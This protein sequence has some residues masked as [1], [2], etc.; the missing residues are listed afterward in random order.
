MSCSDSKNRS[1]GV[2]M[3]IDTSGTYTKQLFRAQR[4]IN[5]LLVN[6]NVGDSLAVARIDSGS[7][8]EKDIIAKITFDERPSTA[9]KQKLAFKKKIDSFVRNA[10]GSNYTDITGGILQA[11]SYLNE[12]GSGKKVILIF[13]DL[14]E[15]LAKGYVRDLSKSK[16]TLD[17]FS[18]IALN[19]IKL[20]S[21]NIDPTKYEER[22]ELWEKRITNKGGKWRL[23]NDLDRPDKILKE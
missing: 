7:F 10:K 23:I 9:N 3:L 6:L 20:R 16:H 17:G 19:V 18:V 21:D 15:E 22:L 14:E 5:H 1:T 12:V 4:I 8:S 11:Q 2:Y 13:S